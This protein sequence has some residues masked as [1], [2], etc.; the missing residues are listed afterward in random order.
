MK[1]GYSQDLLLVGVAQPADLQDV[2]V[3]E[4]LV[5]IRYVKRKDGCLQMAMGNNIQEREDVC[6]NRDGKER[7]HLANA[8]SYLCQHYYPDHRTFLP[9]SFCVLN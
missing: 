2:T 3:F 4:R 7:E 9:A 6:D 1:F 5:E 8:T